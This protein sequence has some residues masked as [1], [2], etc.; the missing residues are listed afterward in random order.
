MFQIGF[1]VIEVHEKEN[2]MVVVESCLHSDYTRKKLY[3]RFHKK[4]V[5]KILQEFPNLHSWLATSSNWNTYKNRFGP[6]S[7]FKLWSKWVGISLFIKE[8]LFPCLS[9][10]NSVEFFLDT[11]SM[12]S[13]MWFTKP[14][15]HE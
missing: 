12:T 11:M 15:E 7:F 6:N 5:E 13:N 4:V 14:Q 10:V 9:E 1:V 3:K 2:L 8:G